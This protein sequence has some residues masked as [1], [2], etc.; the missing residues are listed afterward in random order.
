MRPNTLIRIRAAIGLAVAAETTQEFGGPKLKGARVAIQGFGAVGQHAARFL[1]KNGATLVGASDSH[2]TVAVPEGLDVNALIEL[3][4]QGRKVQTYARGKK[5]E[6][7]DIVGINCDIWIPAARPDVLRANNVEQL[8][9]KLV[10]QGANIPTT[11]EAKHRLYERGLMSIPDFIANAGGVICAAVE[12][13][14]GTEQMAFDTIDEK[15][16]TNTREIS[17]SARSD[18]VSP[19]EAANSLAE[20]RVRAAMTLGR[21]A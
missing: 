8:K 10:L 17:R 15:L 5:L 7:E 13:R 18:R 9:A 21:W 12:Y 2:G 6:R 11:V 14:G 4:R 19:R 16:R 3:K 1:E 20:R